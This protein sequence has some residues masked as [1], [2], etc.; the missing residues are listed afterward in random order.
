ML[1]PT[2]ATGYAPVGTALVAEAR[3]R[4][5]AAG[6]PPLVAI[7]GISLQAAPDVVAAGA[8]AVVVISDLLR[9]GDPGARVRAYLSALGEV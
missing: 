5:D 6:G 4:I 2:K 8:D 3:R 7:G 9:G 1:K